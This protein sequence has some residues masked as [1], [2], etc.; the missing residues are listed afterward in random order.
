MT[1]NLFTLHDLLTPDFRQFSEYGIAAMH[2]AYK[3]LKRYDK[4]HEIEDYVNSVVGLR[5]KCEKL[6]FWKPVK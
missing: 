5:A 6:R 1:P 4:C 2:Q 3:G